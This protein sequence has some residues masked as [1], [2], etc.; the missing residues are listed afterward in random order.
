MVISVSA[1][2]PNIPLSIRKK[3]L[4]LHAKK[5]LQE[6]YGG[7]EGTEYDTDLNVLQGKA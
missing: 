5:L 2:Y 1:R 3:R 6:I 4:C 7:P